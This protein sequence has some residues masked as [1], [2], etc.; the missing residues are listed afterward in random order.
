MATATTT[1]PQTG[2]PVEIQE[3]IAKKDQ[4]IRELEAKVAA[5]EKEK[6]DIVDNFQT[7]TEVLLER[8]KELE[9]VSLGAR[10]QTANILAR[11]GTIFCCFF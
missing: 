9:S 4:R 5:L 10:P 11:I 7:S 1:T 8:I 6:E 2:L 3:L